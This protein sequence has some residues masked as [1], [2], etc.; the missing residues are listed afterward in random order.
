MIGQLWS[1]TR[2]RD[3]HKA[4]WIVKEIEEIGKPRFGIPDEFNVAVLVEYEDS[5]Q[6]DVKM[7]LDVPLR[8]KLCGFPWP[9]DDPIVFAPKGPKALIGEPLRTTQFETLSAAEWELLV[10]GYEVRRRQALAMIY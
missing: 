10:S 7:T 2:R 3:F 5:F 6:A 8:R 4:C 9:K 1:D